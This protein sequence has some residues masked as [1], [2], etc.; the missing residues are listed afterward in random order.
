MRIAIQVMDLQLRSTRDEQIRLAVRVA[1]SV[2]PSSGRHAKT[3]TQKQYAYLS[4][5]SSLSAWLDESNEVIDTT[6]TAAS[7]EVAAQIIS[8]L[9]LH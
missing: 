2:H 7:E 9:M 4:P 6:L 3:P 5:Y 1:A 8:D